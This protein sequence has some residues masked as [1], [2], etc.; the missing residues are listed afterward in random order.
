VRL[1]VRVGVKVQVRAKAEV[2]AG[3]RGSTPSGAPVVSAMWAG[4]A[5]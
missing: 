5:G 3:A 4:M 1:K 2:R